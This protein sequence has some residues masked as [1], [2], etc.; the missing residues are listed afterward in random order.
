[1]GSHDYL[2][3]TEGTRSDERNYLQPPIRGASAVSTLMRG[4]NLIIYP[5]GQNL[6]FPEDDPQFSSGVHS[7]EMAKGECFLCSG[8]TRCRRSR[9][10]FHAYGFPYRIGRNSNLGFHLT[11]GD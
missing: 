4:R 10:H 5:E 6:K 1:V 3:A 9:V 2:L 7:T 11:T 8:M